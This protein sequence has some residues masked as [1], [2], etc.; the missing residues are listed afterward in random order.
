MA[1]P[2]RAQL[3]LPFQEILRAAKGK[4]A[5]SGKVIHELAERVGLSKEDREATFEWGGR[6]LSRW[7]REVR[8][9]KETLKA[10][11]HVVSGGTRGLWQLSDLGEGHL[12]AAKPGVV[13]TVFE[14]VQPGAGTVLWASFEDALGVIEDGVVDLIH[15]SPP[16]PYAG[17]AYGDMD[18]ASWVSFM[19]DAIVAMRPKLAPTGS[20]QWNVAETYKPGLPTKSLHLD[21]LRI[22]LA[23]EAGFH[24]LD[25][26][27][28]HNPN[29]LAVPQSWVATRRIRLKSSVEHLLWISPNP[30][31][32]ADNR[33]LLQPYGDWMRRH[34][35]GEVASPKPGTRACGARFSASGS[36]FARD[37]GGS[38]A[39]VLVTAGVGRKPRALEDGV[40]AE[41]LPAHPAT[42]PQRVAEF[43]IKLA[44]QEGGLV[45]DP[46]AG[47]LTTCRAALHLKRRFV[48]NDKHLG[49]LLG[50]RHAFNARVDN[51][52]LVETALEH[53]RRAA[54]A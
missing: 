11:G 39:S 26:L 24:V 14:L 42:M 38:I 12:L 34:L 1:P 22:R 44:T 17:K 50:G 18:E 6:H 43:G 30:Y 32:E 37:N 8:W 53:Y 5:T 15:C 29:R 40:R 2:P 41:H 36:S 52:A 31:A 25:S 51:D 16:Y 28:W 48:G 47:S 33:R 27:F 23:D 13:V 35:A 46:M 19:Y 45:W 3:A 21:R 7:G 9:V 54:A 20:M 4:K 49:Y 10:K